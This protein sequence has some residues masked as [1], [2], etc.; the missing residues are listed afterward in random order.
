MKLTTNQ[1]TWLNI[2]YEAQLNPRA[3]NILRGNVNDLSEFLQL[4]DTQILKFRNSGPKTLQHIINFKQQLL[5]Q[6][7]SPTTPTLIK[8]ND[9]LA[10]LPVS[11]RNVDIF[12]LR[13]GL[14]N[15]KPLPLHVIGKRYNL[16]KE[17]IRQIITQ[18]KNY[19]L[20]R[21]KLINGNIHDL[22][23]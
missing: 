9:I 15:E 5:E 8:L 20:Q 10:T 17:R 1:Q 7:I 14:R 11:P 19:V 2:L 23:K 21:S 16:S 6:L 12:S 13:F 3:F 18:V 22:L 4:T